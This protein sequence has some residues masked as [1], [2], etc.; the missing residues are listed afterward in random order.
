MPRNE[1]EKHGKTVFSAISH[2]VSVRAEGFVCAISKVIHSAG[3]ESTPKCF[4]PPVLQCV[5]CGVSVS[6]VQSQ[7]CSEVLGQHRRAARHTLDSCHI[8]C[9]SNFGSWCIR[10][11]LL[12]HSI[13]WELWDPLWSCS[14]QLK[15]LRSRAKSVS[16]F[17]GIEAWAM[18][19]DVALTEASVQLFLWYF[20]PSP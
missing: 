19:V 16:D 3:P 17:L 13:F 6:H 14:L 15:Q 4:G 5:Q 8:L 7:D 12:L 11:S 10:K 18:V 2:H 20:L 1:V 9:R